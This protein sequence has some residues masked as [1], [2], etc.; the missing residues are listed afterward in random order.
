VLGCPF[1][2]DTTLLPF[3]PP[4]VTPSPDVG[5]EKKIENETDHRKKNEDYKPGYG[6]VPKKCRK[7]PLK[8]PPSPKRTLPAAASSS[9]LEKRKSAVAKPKRKRRRNPVPFD[10]FRAAHPSFGRRL[11]EKTQ[12]FSLSRT[13]KKRLPKNRQ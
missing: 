12:V 7:A 13:E 5:S 6:P 8:D 2:A 9:H 11:R 3:Q 4:K 1:L 10:L